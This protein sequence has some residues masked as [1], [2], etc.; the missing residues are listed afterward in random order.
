MWYFVH[1]RV[2]TIKLT[3]F[4]RFDD[5]TVDLGNNPK[6]L[7]ALVGPNGSGKSSI[8]DAFE[9]L[10][11]EH[12][13]ANNGME[14]SFYSKR[15][16][17]AANPV[18]S[19]SK[20]DAI[21]LTTADGKATTNTSFYVRSAYRFSPRLKVTA[22]KEQP[23]ART[24][25]TRPG[26]SISLDQRLQ[27]NYERLLGRLIS[28]FWEK[29]GK[30]GDEVRTELI[31]RLNVRLSNV[32]DVRISNL[33]NVS[34]GKGQLFFEKGTSKDFPFEN[35]SSGEKEVVDM[36]LDLEVKLSVYTDT[37][38]CIDEPEL[39]LNTAIQRKLLRELADMIPDSCQLWVATHSIG[40]LR[41]LQQD[42][43]N[44]AQILDFSEKEYFT[45]SHTIKPIRGTRADWKRI[46]STALEDLTGLVAPTTIIYCEGK[47][48][49]GIAGAEQG[50]N[51]RVYNT[52]FE[53]VA[54]T[55]FISSGGGGA[56]EKHS[57]VA[58]KILSKAFQ[59]VA[60]R[61]LKDRDDS[62]DAERQAFLAVSGEHR[63]LERREIENYLFDP[64]ILGS[65]VAGK[66]AGLD[67][68]KYDAIVTDIGTQDLKLGQTLQRLKALCGFGGTVEEFKLALAPFLAEGTAVYGEL[69]SCA[70]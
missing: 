60:L 7:V 17:D 69:K 32:L 33:G 1:M 45:G 68:T 4:K 65:Y 63:M 3:H 10:L 12:V 53:E 34:E 52:V 13:G 59:G 11:Q 70:L 31:G 23:D 6:K 57:G 14:A 41:A 51:A 16:F 24:D 35:L 66:G 15:W 26:N 54:D 2:S 55:L 61:L 42:L 38:I 39:H 18:Q 20:H 50:L 56:Q 21:S 40:F 44:D 37:V 9:Q 62:S 27:G 30:T 29:G 5:L 58:L 22:V 46:F 36:L 64:E 49:P 28:S 25:A 67:R 19:Y 47:P 8:F 48:E 43:G